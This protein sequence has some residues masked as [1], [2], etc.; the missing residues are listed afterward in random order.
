VSFILV[1]V[2]ARRRHA[3]IAGKTLAKC[4]ELSSTSHMNENSTSG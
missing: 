4:V 1:F 2:F 3:A